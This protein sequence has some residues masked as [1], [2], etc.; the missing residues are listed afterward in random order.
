MLAWF[1]WYFSS[2]ARFFRIQK[3]SQTFLL[4]GRNA[5]WRHHELSAASTCFDPFA[6]PDIPPRR[7][8]WTITRHTRTSTCL[9][10]VTEKS[11]RLHIVFTKSCLRVKWWPLRSQSNYKASPTPPHG[12]FRFHLTRRACVER[13]QPAGIMTACVLTIRTWC[14][15]KLSVPATDY[16]VKAQPHSCIDRRPMHWRSGDWRQSGC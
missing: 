12:I 16:N 7:C 15:G 14:R 9:T 6:S 2:L 8:E 10:S 13:A 5:L 1:Q 11:A 3:V 4:I